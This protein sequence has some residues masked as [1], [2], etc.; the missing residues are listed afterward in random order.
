MEIGCQGV[1]K[2]GKRLGTT[3]V[4]KEP[5]SPVQRRMGGPQ[6]WA[7]RVRALPPPGYKPQ[8]YQ[9]IV[10]CRTDKTIPVRYY[11]CIFLSN[12]FLLSVL[13]FISNIIIV[14]S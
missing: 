11:S 13:A 9:P 7:G 1:R 5:R 6:D 3:A 8:T 2:W 10:S 4:G 12:F 14:I